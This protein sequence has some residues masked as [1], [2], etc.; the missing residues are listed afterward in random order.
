MDTPQKTRDQGHEFFAVPTG[1][2]FPCGEYRSQDSTIDDLIVKYRDA[3]EE[4]HRSYTNIDIH[5]PSTIDQ[6]L[7]KSI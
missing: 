1:K 7:V 6:T 3:I 5:L 2:D 4:S